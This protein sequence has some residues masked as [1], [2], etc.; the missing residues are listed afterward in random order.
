MKRT[1][2]ICGGQIVE[3]KV[4][5][6]ISGLSMGQF[7]GYKCKKCGEE[8]LA[9]HSLDLAHEEIVRTGLFGIARETRLTLPTVAGFWSA[10]DKRLWA[11]GFY[12]RADTVHRRF[13]FYSSS[14]VLEASVSAS[15]S[16]R[17]RVEGDSH[18]SFIDALK[19]EET[20]NGTRVEHLYQ[21]PM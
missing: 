13:V 12:S 18:L 4:G 5:V 17:T 1:C 8:F 3:A 10:S 15:S 16:N 20:Q 7:D 19:L 9:E 21:A 11:T 14:P 2:P 6:V